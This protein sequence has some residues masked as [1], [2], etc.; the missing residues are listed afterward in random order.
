MEI[1]QVLV[2]LL[3]NALDAVQSLKEKWVRLE[4]DHQEDSVTVA[5]TDSGAGIP[6]E[7]NDRMFEP[8]FTTKPTGMGTGLGLS[9]SKRI[10]ERHGGTLMIDRSSPHT[11][12][13]VR[14]PAAREERGT[15]AA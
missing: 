12:F 1:S 3:I 4:V 10:I 8:L 13:M 5:V 15:N 7:I 9:I 11:R 6:P 2:N 14:S